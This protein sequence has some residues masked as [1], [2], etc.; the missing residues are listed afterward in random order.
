MLVKLFLC[1]DPYCLKSIRQPVHVLNEVHRANAWTDALIISVFIYTFPSSLQLTSLF[2]IT[3]F[4]EDF[5]LPIE[6]VKT[7]VVVIAE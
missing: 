4:L 5:F 1:L 7:T 2:M 3:L 6:T